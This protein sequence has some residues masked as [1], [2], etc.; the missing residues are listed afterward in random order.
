MIVVVLLAEMIEVSLAVD[1]V[2]VVILHLVAEVSVV[3]AGMVGYI[4]VEGFAVVG[5][6]VEEVADLYFQDNLLI[7]IFLRH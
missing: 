1:I 4:S 6:E 5:F 2:A 3:W 7:Q